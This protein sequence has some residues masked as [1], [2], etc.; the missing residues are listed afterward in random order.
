MGRR[1]WWRGSTGDG[2]ARDG[3]TMGA[4]KNRHSQEGARR[5]VRWCAVSSFVWLFYT[6]YTVLTVLLRVDESPVGRATTLTSNDSALS[7]GQASAGRSAGCWRGRCGSGGGGS[8]I[9]PLASGP[10]RG[11][12]P[13]T[14]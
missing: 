14:V 5:R 6:P 9:Q 11:P 12:P 1:R 7:L 3:V 13:R 2:L 8:A 4:S 10:R